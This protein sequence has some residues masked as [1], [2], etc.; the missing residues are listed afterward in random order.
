MKVTARANGAQIEITVGGG[1]SRQKL[2]LTPQR[3][4]EL[5]EQLAG[6]TG[7]A[8]R[9]G[10]IA[11][12]LPPAQARSTLNISRWSFLTLSRP[13]GGASL[14]ISPKAWVA[15]DLEL[16]AQPARSL[17]ESLIASADLLERGRLIN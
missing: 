5:A 7:E 4:I 6:A 13:E 11:P 2:S 15:Y 3:A 10:G 9:N 8:I 14:V 16:Q 17:G 1:T 12:S